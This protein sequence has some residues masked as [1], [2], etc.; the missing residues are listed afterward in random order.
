MISN[1]VG[2]D[3]N[4]I[5]LLNSATKLRGVKFTEEFYIY[6]KSGSEYISAW[7]DIPLYADSGNKVCRAW[8]DIQLYADSGNTVGSTVLKTRTFP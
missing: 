5:D 3:I 1:Q 2:H 4:F 6:F 7:H 8:H